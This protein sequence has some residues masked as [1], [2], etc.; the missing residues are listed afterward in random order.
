M[1]SGRRAVEAEF[2][3]GNSIVEWVREKLVTGKKREAW[4]VLDPTLA[5]AVGCREVREEMMLVLRVALLCSSQ[6]PANRPS[7][8]DVVLM[9]RAAKPQKKAV[10]GEE[11]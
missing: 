6:N 5:G 11:Q 9:L 4:E 1:V 10:A 7:M 8:R 2:G 3:E